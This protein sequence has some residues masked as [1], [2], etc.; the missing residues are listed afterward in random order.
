MLELEERVREAL[1]ATAEEVGAPSEHLDDKVLLRRRQR[2]QRR[3]GGAAVLAAAAVVATVV[4]AGRLPGDDDRP[5]QVTTGSPAEAD[6]TAPLILVPGHVPEDLSLVA[7]SGGDRPEDHIA[8]AELSPWDHTQR[9]VDYDDAESQVLAVLDLHWGLSRSDGTEPTEPAGTASVPLPGD[10]DGVL[11]AAP[12]LPTEVLTELAGM[13]VPRE[14]GGFT[15]PSA[16]LH[17]ELAAEWSEPVDQGSNPRSLVYRSGDGARGL[18]V[19]VVDDGP[20]PVA[21]LSLTTATYV[22]TVR[23]NEALS[24]TALV[25]RPLVEVEEG[26]FL[27]DSDWHLLWTEPGGE[28][29]AVD[30]VG[31]TEDELLAVAES[32]TEVDAATWFGLQEPDEP[33]TST[34]TTAVVEAAGDEAPASPEAGSLVVSGRYEGTDSYVLSDGDP[35]DIEHDDQVTLTLDDGTTWQLDHQQCGLTLPGDR[36]SATGTFTITLPGGDSLTGTNSQEPIQL[37]T[38]GEPF[39]LDIEGGTGDLAGAT[40]WCDLDNHLRNQSLGSQEMYGDFTCEVAA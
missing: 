20:P 12:P 19:H 5:A 4:V 25:G 22:R 6:P 34:P 33:A 14:E 16:P 30:A 28:V 7:A 40:G 38:T 29:V 3:R 27:S 21:A 2:A 32:L 24:G 39:R 11:T 17:F 10:E 36:W 8:T 13:V 9:W 31:F 18:Q 37:P 35:C 15:F 26:A 23:G 1:R